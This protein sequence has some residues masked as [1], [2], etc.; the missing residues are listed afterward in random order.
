[1]ADME[2]DEKAVEETEEETVS[3]GYPVKMIVISVALL[4]VIGVIGGVGTKFLLSDKDTTDSSKPELEARGNKKEQRPVASR[5]KLGAIYPMDTFI[6]NLRDE[7]VTKYLKVA[8]NLELENEK[9]AEELKERHP[10]IR[11]ALIILLSSKESV[12]VMSIEG[13]FQLRDEII[14]AVNKVVGR[15]KVRNAYF[16]DFV[17]Q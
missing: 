5:E 12:D 9:W 2:D 16:T 15:G 13:K 17:I 14:S 6:V 4:L 1:M 10:Q 7:K 3:R 11:D 8:V